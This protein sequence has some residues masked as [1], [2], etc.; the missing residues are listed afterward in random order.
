[1]SLPDLRTLEYPRSCCESDTDDS[2]NE[3]QREFI[4]A[5]PALFLSLSSDSEGSEIEDS[6]C[7]DTTDKYV[8]DNYQEDRTWFINWLC[9]FEKKINL[10]KSLFSLNYR[11]DPL[12]L[13]RVK[14]R[15]N[16]NYTFFITSLNR[17][18][19]DIKMRD[20]NKKSAF[21]VLF[22]IINL[23]KNSTC[24]I[25][26]DDK[27][28]DL[29]VKILVDWIS[30]YT[31]SDGNFDQIR[32]FLKDYYNAEN[33]KM[34]SLVNAWV[35]SDFYQLESKNLLMTKRSY[36]ESI[37]FRNLTTFFD[38][39][40][41]K[42]SEILSALMDVGQFDINGLT[43]FLKVNQIPFAGPFKKAES[44]GELK[45]Q[46]FISSCNPADSIVNLNMPL[47]GIY[48]LTKKSY[49]MRQDDA[50][51]RISCLQTAP[52]WLNH[53]PPLFNLPIECFKR[54]IDAL[55][56]YFNV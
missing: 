49:R 13:A 39:E 8:E 14:S 32:F 55:D 56:I 33:L 10:L 48:E 42:N 41:Q 11:I 21:L 4:N 12:K 52:D 51:R 43:D 22:D 34:S 47:Y 1:M 19:S 37:Y 16:Q 35:S 5:S 30:S 26:F 9:H 6:F 2:E 54:Q 44:N 46:F 38:S 23:F 7:D 29:L 36:I 31:F 40:L 3:S 53:I 27:I 28:S 50:A 17:I 20:N 24:K 15:N 18:S 45:V 25:L